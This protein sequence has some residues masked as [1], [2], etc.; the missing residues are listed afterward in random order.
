MET[1]V[2]GNPRRP[3]S[4]WRRSIV[5]MS[6]LALGIGVLVLLGIIVGLIIAFAGTRD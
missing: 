3:I 5:G 2:E 4:A 1:A 6:F